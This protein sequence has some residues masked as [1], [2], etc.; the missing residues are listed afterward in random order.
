[1]TNMLFK[2]EGRGANGSQYSLSFKTTADAQVEAR[3]TSLSGRVVSDMGGGRAAVSG[4]ITRLLWNGRGRGG[5]SL[6]AGPYRVEVTA[7]GEEGELATEIRPITLL[8]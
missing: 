5:E 2:R 4:G 6:P 7:R 1:V 8:R 3:I